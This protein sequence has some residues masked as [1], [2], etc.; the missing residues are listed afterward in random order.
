MQFFK[1]ILKLDAASAKQREQRGANRY[2]IGPNFPLRAVL[3]L[4]GRCDDGRILKSKDGKGW[5][6]SGRLVNVSTTGVSL[7]L[8]P[9]IHAARGDQCH[10]K[11]TIDGHELE[12]PSR[13]VHRREQRDSAV[14]GVSLSFTDTDVPSAYHQLL[15]L[16]ALGA[17]LQPVKAAEETAVAGEFV[18]ELC[19]GDTGGQLTIWRKTEDKTIHA[20]EFHL[21]DCCIQGGPKWIEFLSRKQ[22]DAYKA[23]GATEAEEIRRLFRWVAPN[24]AKAVPSDVRSFLQDCAK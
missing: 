22:A 9:A 21:T 1:R 19:R 7:Q 10:L 13:I 12:I 15:E 4:Q 5:D 18:S 2:S 3:N 17:T 24:I 14:F 23:A 20:F 11:L 16:I 8:P 6:W